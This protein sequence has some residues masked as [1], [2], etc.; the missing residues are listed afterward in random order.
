VVENGWKM[1][2]KMWK[3]VFRFKGL[4]QWVE[5]FPTIFQQSTPA[6]PADFEGL[7]NDVL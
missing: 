2:G 3:T 6:F 7:K 4:I 5:Y 1:G